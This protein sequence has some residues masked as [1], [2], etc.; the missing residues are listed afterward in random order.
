MGKNK[1]NKKPESAKKGAVKERKKVSAL[2]QHMAETRAAV[3]LQKAMKEQKLA[4]QAAA[5]EAL[6][7]ES[8]ELARKA[9]AR[10]AKGLKY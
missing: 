8:A 1:S 7:A 10:A 9:E 3:K 6:E 2:V 5:K 4:A